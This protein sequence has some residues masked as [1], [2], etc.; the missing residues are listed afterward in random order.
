MGRILERGTTAALNEIGNRVLLLHPESVATQED[1][2]VRKNYL[3]SEEIRPAAGPL[4]ESLIW[5]C[6][7]TERRPGQCG[8]SGRDPTSNLLDR[9]GAVHPAA[10]QHQE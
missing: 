4:H 6:P 7:L 3:H 1:T 5:V 9:G 2:E 8:S 10:L